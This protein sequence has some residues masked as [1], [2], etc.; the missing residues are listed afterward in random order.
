MGAAH[1]EALLALAGGP[2]AG[3]LQLDA[4][5]CTAALRQLL[6]ACM[7]ADAAPLALSEPLQ[8]LVGGLLE[9][10]ALHLQVR[11]S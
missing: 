11:A 4:D 6:R 7:Y 1:G 10:R 9:E 5:G 3:R 2:H 8:L